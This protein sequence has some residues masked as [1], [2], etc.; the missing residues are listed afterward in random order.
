MQF[1]RKK[2]KRYS[3]LALVIFHITMV[4]I[5]DNYGNNKVIALLVYMAYALFIVGFFWILY[6]YPEKFKD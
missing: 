2:W 4:T 3:L 5:L 6:R 1:L